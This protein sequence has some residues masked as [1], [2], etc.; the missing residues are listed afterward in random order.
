MGD[1][2]RGRD[3]RE[4]VA[5]VEVAGVGGKERGRSRDGRREV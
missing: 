3:K 1:S 5:G 2:E 4:E